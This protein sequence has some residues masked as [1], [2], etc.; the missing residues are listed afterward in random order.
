MAHSVG[1]SGVSV[2][3]DALLKLREGARRLPFAFRGR[4]LATRSGGHLSRFRGRGMEFDESRLYQPGDERRAMDWR[5]TARTGQPHVKVYREERER[6]VCFC[7]DL[8]PSM[9]FGTR[10]AFKSV[11]A[12][13]IAAMLAWRAADDGDRIGGLVF[14]ETQRVELK[15]V[16]RTRGLL[17]FLKTLCL[18]P[19]PGRRDGYPD[20][21]VAMDDFARLVRP[22][23]LVFVLSD[24]CAISRAKP[25]WLA[26]LAAHSETILIAVHD[27]LEASAPPP[28]R[29]PA[30]DGVEQRVLNTIPAA[31]RK[32]HEER[33]T[34]QRDALVELARAHRAHLVTIGTHEPVAG[35]LSRRLHPGRGK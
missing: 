31:Y 17:P 27:P 29:Y 4:V 16:A 13:E 2:S 28:G 15:P 20:L 33:F 3:L 35:A 11:V 6:P 21:N 34:A 32:A 22:G 14:D 12:A 7:V 18:P 19:E 8:G 24:F 30:T 1:A 23:S 5:V 26:R 9:R 10:R 25:T